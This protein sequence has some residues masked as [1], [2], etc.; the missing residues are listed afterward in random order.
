MICS[1]LILSIYK[2]HSAYTWDE[3]AKAIRR[4]YDG[5][6]QVLV[7]KYQ[8]EWVNWPLS[9]WGCQ[10][11]WCVW[12][13]CYTCV[14]GFVYMNLLVVLFN[15]CRYEALHGLSMLPLLPPRGDTQWCNPSSW[16]LRVQ[17]RC[18]FSSLGDIWCR[19]GIQV[20]LASL[21]FHSFKTKIAC[22]QRFIYCN[23]FYRCYCANH[24]GPPST[25]C[26]TM[27]IGGRRN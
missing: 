17:A 23:F 3:L 5:I 6:N 27:R 15:T 7:L 19:P 16:D 8:L 22:H 25:A 13:I 12:M 9:Q 11:W 26:L 21:S 24:A 4:S 1:I 2:A 10:N 18:T 14:H 20:C